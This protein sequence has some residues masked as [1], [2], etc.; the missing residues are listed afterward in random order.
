MW[1]VRFTLASM[2]E[3]ECPNKLY[4]I[5]LVLY[6]RKKISAN[7]VRQFFEV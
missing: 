1:Y 6:S 3:N 7:C 4:C 2:E 5:L